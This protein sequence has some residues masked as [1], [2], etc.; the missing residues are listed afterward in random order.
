MS[1]TDR[2]WTFIRIL[3]VKLDEY[4]R[5]LYQVEWQDSVWKGSVSSFNELTLDDALLS[6]MTNS[7]R[8]IGK[9]ENELHI[10]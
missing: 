3:S 2:N 9:N 1:L 7:V 10:A 6:G 8:P 5:C 4:Q